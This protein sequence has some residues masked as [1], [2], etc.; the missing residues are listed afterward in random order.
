[1]KA[2]TSIA[3]IVLCALVYIMLRTVPLLLT[4]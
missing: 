2:S 1:M 3:V 4:H